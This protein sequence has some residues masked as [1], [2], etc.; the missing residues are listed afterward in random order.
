MAR[1]MTSSTSIWIM[2]SAGWFHE[3]RTQNHSRNERIGQVWYRWGTVGSICFIYYLS[4]F[5][6]YIF[7]CSLAVLTALKTRNYNVERNKKSY[8]LLYSSGSWSRSKGTLWQSFSGDPVRLWGWSSWYLNFG[9][10]KSQVM[11]CCFQN[12]I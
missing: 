4:F 12:K 2:S 10:H 3:L 6:N 1:K 11:G 5:L 7:H 9:A 8:C